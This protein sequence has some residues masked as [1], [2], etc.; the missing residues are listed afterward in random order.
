MR[1]VQNNFPSFY[2]QQLSVGSF[3]HTSPILVSP[4][5]S[6][7]RRTRNQGERDETGEIHTHKDTVGWSPI[8]VDSSIPHSQI[9]VCH[10]KRTDIL[11]LILPSSS[12]SSPFWN[13]NML[14]GS[15]SIFLRHCHER[16]II[17][18]SWES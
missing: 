3:V 10:H 6:W 9:V 11:I 4:I 8:H 16:Y 12:S 13:W 5:P 14:G 1:F 18:P 7:R 15:T 17:T 2:W